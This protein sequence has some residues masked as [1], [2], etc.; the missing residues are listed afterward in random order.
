MAEP[1]TDTRDQ[2]D[3]AR[4]AATAAAF[5]ARSRRVMLLRRILPVAIVVLAGGTISWIVLR[6]V[7]SDVERK[8][9]TSREIRLDNPMF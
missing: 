8:A 4:V 2:A 3:E 5:R 6:S 1:G 9:G 7:M